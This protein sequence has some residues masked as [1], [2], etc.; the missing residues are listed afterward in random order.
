MKYGVLRECN[1][2]KFRDVVGS[3]V[4]LYSLLFFIMYIIVMLSLLS[5]FHICCTAMCA[6]FFKV[7]IYWTFH[8]STSSSCSTLPTYRGIT[9]SQSYF[10]Q[11]FFESCVLYKFGD[12]FIGH[13]LQFGFKKGF[14]CNAAILVRNKLLNILLIGAVVYICLLLMQTRSLIGL[15]IANW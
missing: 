12:L 13:I 14:G 1:I 15:I 5:L 10:F 8:C 2:S 6:T 9:I 11:N 7:N 4:M 3:H